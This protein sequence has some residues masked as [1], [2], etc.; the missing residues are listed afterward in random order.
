MI[1]LRNR[2]R[3]PKAVQEEFQHFADRVGLFLGQI[4]DQDGQFIS[5]E[6]TLPSLN[7][8]IDVFH[9]DVSFGTND[10]GGTDVA[11][12]NS[13]VLLVDANGQSPTD[14]DEIRLTVHG[15]WTVLGTSSLW[16]MDAHLINATQVQFHKRRINGA[17][18]SDT[19]STHYFTVEWVRR[20]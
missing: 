16:E 1:E 11:T 9:G 3:Y 5:P 19:P 15:P 7:A 18:G 12:K 8:S 14:I 13:T 10:S 17:A 2:G 20:R 6:L 4:F